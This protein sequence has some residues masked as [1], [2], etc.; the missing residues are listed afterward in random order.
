MAGEEG[1]KHNIQDAYQ[2]GNWWK[3]SFIYSCCL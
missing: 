1:S 3:L 2:R